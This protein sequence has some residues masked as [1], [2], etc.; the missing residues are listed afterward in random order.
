MLK[1]IEAH[2]PL[3]GRFYS[4]I[5]VEPMDNYEA[6]SFY[7]SVPLDDKVRYYSV[8][9]GIPYFLGMIDV[10]K[11]SAEN[12]IDLIIKDNSPLESEIKSTI[13]GEYS[14]IEN[15]SFV[16]PLIES[17]CHSFGDKKRIFTPGHQ[18][19]ICHTH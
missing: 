2:S 12:V 7:P 10:T 14:K 8:F 15:A 11:T 9:G 3:H 4:L 1:I 17:G 18:K 16:M 19:A 13:A 5:S 6:S